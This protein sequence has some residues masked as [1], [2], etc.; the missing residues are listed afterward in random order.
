MP[1]SVD[2]EQ[3]AS[4]RAFI[5]FDD[6]AQTASHPSGFSLFEFGFL[7]HHTINAEGMLWSCEPCLP[8]SGYITGSREQAS[9]SSHTTQPTSILI[10]DFTPHTALAPSRV[11]FGRCDLLSR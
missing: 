3:I 4:R 6:E 8:E 10:M 7:R 1:I 9:V 5:G 11:V 2:A